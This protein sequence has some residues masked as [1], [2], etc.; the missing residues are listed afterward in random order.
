LIVYA[1]SSDI[2]DLIQ[3]LE[4]LQLALPSEQK[5]TRWKVLCGVTMGAKLFSKLNRALNYNHAHA[6]PGIHPLHILFEWSKFLVKPTWSF[7][8]TQK[9]TYSCITLA[10]RLCLFILMATGG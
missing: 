9:T 1:L 8:H 10:V 5:Y 4:F 3:Q 7:P 6:V 2:Y